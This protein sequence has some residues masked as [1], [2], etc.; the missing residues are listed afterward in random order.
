MKILNGKLLSEK[1]FKDIFNEVQDLKKNYN[2]IPGLAVCLVGDNP[3]SE[4]YVR[5]KIK[6]CERVGFYSVLKKFPSDISKE[7]LKKEI[8]M[9]NADKNIHGLLVQLPLPKGL[10]E[11]EVLSWLDPLKDVDALTLENK[12]LLWQGAPRVVPCTPKG[13]I[14]LLKHY[15]ISIKGKTA[16]VV[17]RSQIV[18]LPMFQ[19][20]LS[21]QATVTVCHSQTKNLSEVCR[22]ADIVVACAG[23]KGLLSKRDFKKGA[24]VVDVGIHRV[25]KKLYGDVDTEGL[26]EH[27]SALSLVPG[28]VGPMTI[29]SLLENCL[30]IAKLSCWNKR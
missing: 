28:G 20:L 11:K 10:Y 19:Q 1:I 25:D 12:A 2:L 4:V 23:V 13:I 24:V 3:A 9:L 21:H 7:N 18:G 26:K 5:N 17:G 16:V 8:L 22:S 27:L 29:A 6:A 14:S 15:E 30:E